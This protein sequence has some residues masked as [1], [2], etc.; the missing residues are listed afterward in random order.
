VPHDPDA[1]LP[2]ANRDRFQ[3]PHCDTYAQQEWH[4]VVR[5]R[6]HALP[7]WRCSLCASCGRP[8]LWIDDQLI[9]PSDRAGPPPSP[10]LP[11]TV[12]DAYQEARRVAPISPRS[13]A[14]LLRL[15]LQILVDGV[16]PGRGD[17]NEKIGKLAAS[18]LHPGIIQA[19]DALRVFG[20]NAVHPGQIALD[21]LE[22]VISLFA[23]LNLL[24]EVLVGEPARVQRLYEMLPVGARQ[25]IKRRDAREG[26][27]A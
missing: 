21:D 6:G 5:E 16:Q 27:A 19:M 23:L 17:L 26:S 7:G 3:C 2:A 18:G 14:A 8:A 15:G 12:R 25:S 20:N 22:V 1:K 11:E 9:Y 13:A 10:D 4:A 24:G